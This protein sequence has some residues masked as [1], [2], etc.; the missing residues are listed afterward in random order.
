MWESQ[1]TKRQTSLKTPMP[2]LLL[3]LLCGKHC[4]GLIHREAE[5]SGARRCGG[6]RKV[7]ERGEVHVERVRH[8]VHGGA[9]PPG[10]R[11]CRCPASSTCSRA[12]VTRRALQPPAIIMVTKVWC[13]SWNVQSKPLILQNAAKSLPSIV[14]LQGRLSGSWVPRMS[15]AP[16]L[17]PG[18]LSHAATSAE[19]NPWPAADCRL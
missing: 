5:R 2:C 1:R 17:F 6:L 13:M 10:P 8:L 19:A 11:R 18:S 15:A 4:P 3:F 14:G 9:W 16:V 12:L 7:A